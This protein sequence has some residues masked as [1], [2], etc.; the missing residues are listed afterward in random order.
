MV[1]SQAF[2]Y[3]AKEL[4]GGKFYP[5]RKGGAA[6]RYRFHEWDLFDI[7]TEA[8]RRNYKFRAVREEEVIVFGWDADVDRLYIPFRIDS[9]G[10]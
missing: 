6:Y 8:G 9:W 2:Q 10:P 5:K 7:H 4:P 1:I 3:L